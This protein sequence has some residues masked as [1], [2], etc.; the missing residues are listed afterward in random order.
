DDFFTAAPVSLDFFDRWWTLERYHGVEGDLDLIAGDLPPAVVAAFTPTG[1]ELVDAWI[2]DLKAGKRYHSP[3]TVPLPTA[4]MTR[5]GQRLVGDLGDAKGALP[6]L[7][8]RGEPLK[9]AVTDEFLGGVMGGR[10]VEVADVANE[11]LAPEDH[12]RR[13]QV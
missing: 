8:G 9:N 12:E 11:P 2:A 6:P 10:E 3:V 4:F 1:N 7:R 5:G 13:R